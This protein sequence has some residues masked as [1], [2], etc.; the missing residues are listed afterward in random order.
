[1]R[2]NTASHHNNNAS[3]TIFPLNHS[4]SF[5]SKEI[6]SDELNNNSDPATMD[7]KPQSLEIM[8]VLFSAFGRIFDIV[9]YPDHKKISAREKHGHSGK[10]EFTQSIFYH[11]YLKGMKKESEVSLT[12]HNMELVSVKKVMFHYNIHK[13]NNNQIFNVRRITSSRILFTSANYVKLLLSR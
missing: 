6:V 12:F 7:T 8:N 4:P 10:S 2:T 9:L 11:G 1:M 5:S 13:F 3:E